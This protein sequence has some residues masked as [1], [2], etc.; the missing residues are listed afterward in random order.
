MRVLRTEDWGRLG[1]FWRQAAADYTY[2]DQRP[3]GISIYNLIGDPTL[4]F[5]VSR[6]APPPRRK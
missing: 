2:Y 3:M 6:P 5:S 4:R 1:D